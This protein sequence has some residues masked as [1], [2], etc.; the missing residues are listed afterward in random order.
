MAMLQTRTADGDE[1]LQ[2]LDILGNLLEE[3]KGGA[4]NI[5]VGMLLEGVNVNIK[6]MLV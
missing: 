6:T 5:F 1:R 2:D 3:S 4:T